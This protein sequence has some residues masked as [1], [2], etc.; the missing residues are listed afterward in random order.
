MKEAIL[1]IDM[2]NDFVYDKFGSKGAQKI[3]PRLKD[4]LETAQDSDKLIIYAQDA[5]TEEDPEMDIWGKHGMRG[6]KGSV[7]IDELKGFEDYMV[8]TSTYDPFFKTN[9]NK[10]LKDDE[11]KSVI[12]T[13]VSTDICV[14]HAAG[15]AFI[16]GYDVTVLDDC[17]AAMAGENY[18]SALEYMKKIYGAEISTSKE[19]KKRWG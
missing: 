9:L 7:T 18:E 10:I 8:E 4:L 6:E 3:V 12:I 19:I 5:H 14:Q 1:V 13:G 17:T 2:I 11:I 16:R 15:G